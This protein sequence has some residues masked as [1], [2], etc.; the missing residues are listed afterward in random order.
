MIWDCFTY[1]GERDLLTVTIE[2]FKHLEPLRKTME[3]RHVIIESRYTFTGIE[4]PFSLTLEDIDK[5]N[6]EWFPL[7]D[8]PHKDAW[9]NER[10]QRNFI[11]TALISLGVQDDDIVIIRDIDEIPRAYAVQHYRPE[12]GL[13]ALQMDMFYYYLNVLSARNEWILPRI[14]TWD[15]L[16]D[17][18]PDEVRRSGFDY[19]LFQAGWHFCW[20]GG[21]DMMLKKF[22]SFSHQEPGVQALANK[23]ILQGKLNRI[24]SLW[25]DEKFK[26]VGLNE[27]PWYVQ[28]HPEE[29][30]HMLYAPPVQG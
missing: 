1:C 20:Q 18:Q 5:Y 14:M 29:F 8:I 6:L 4:K 11:K 17:R 24:E 26:V 12:F 13:V 16:K 10:R 28:Q 30:K 23:E 19:C 7:N 2:E 25:G 3:V 22:K 27:L 21:M 15:Y 9:E